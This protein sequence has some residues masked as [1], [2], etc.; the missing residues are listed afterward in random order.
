MNKK[1]TIFILNLLLL[2][3]SSFLI[4]FCFNFSIKIGLTVKLSAVIGVTILWA[5]FAYM[6]RFTSPVRSVNRMLVIPSSMIHALFLTIIMYLY[7]FSSSQRFQTVIF[8]LSVPLYFLGLAVMV[9]FVVAMFYSSFK[10]G[11]V[12]KNWIIVPAALCFLPIIQFN[13]I[14]VLVMFPLF[15]L[16]VLAVIL[17][18]Y[19]YIML[20]PIGRVNIL[21]RSMEA[22]VAISS[23]FAAYIAAYWVILRNIS[24]AP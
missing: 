15:A 16:L 17:L 7:L 9:G 4:Y 21:V 3:F 19:C 2:Y 12:K 11:Q 8:T 13:N 1:K 23:A 18:V 10:R 22:F 24:R 6:L 5:V 14:F 20:E